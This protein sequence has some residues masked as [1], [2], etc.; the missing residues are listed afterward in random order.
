MDQPT[1]SMPM[2]DMKFEPK[3]IED[4]KV[5]AALSYISVLV[6]IPLLTK[7]DSPFAQ[8]H[9]KQGLVMLIAEVILS[10]IPFLGWILLS[11]VLIINIIALV[12]ALMGKFWKI[13]GAYDM[14]KKFN[15]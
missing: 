14:S 2:G 12:N 4:N 13:P 1:P 7:K 9:A 11:V 8:A 6:F 10:I 3:D 15:I 5:I